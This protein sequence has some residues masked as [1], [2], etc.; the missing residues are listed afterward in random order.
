MNKNIYKQY[1]FISSIYFMYYYNYIHYIKK[2]NKNIKI[3][4]IIK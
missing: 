2:K 1:I 3:F 4:I